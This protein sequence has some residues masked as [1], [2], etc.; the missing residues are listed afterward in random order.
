MCVL[1]RS[2][3]DSGVGESAGSPCVASR[4][5]SQSVIGL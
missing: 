2:L 5:V 1:S 3:G 4:S